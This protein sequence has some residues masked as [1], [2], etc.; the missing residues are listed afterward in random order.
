VGKAVARSEWAPL[1]RVVVRRPG[2]EVFF[3][4]LEPY[5]SLYER[6]FSLEKARR[7]HDELVQTLRRGFGVEVL[8]LE[9][10]LL[11]GAGRDPSLA[12]EILRRVLAT[13]QFVG[14]GAR[15]ARQEFAENLPLLDRDQLLEILT[16]SPSLT[17]VR[18]KGTRNILPFTTLKVPLTN[19]FFL[20]DQQAVGTGGSSWRARPSHSGGGRRR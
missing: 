5:S 19:L 15:R 6:V 4:L 1:R 8:Y 13:V 7:E 16:L 12:E 11:E 17:L 20:R 10:I 2:L 18:K 9:E 3:G 14:P